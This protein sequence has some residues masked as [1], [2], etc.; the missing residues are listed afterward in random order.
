MLTCININLA[1]GD[2]CRSITMGLP[3]AVKAHEYK[4][5]IEL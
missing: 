4:F 1:E 5:V 2:S 3:L